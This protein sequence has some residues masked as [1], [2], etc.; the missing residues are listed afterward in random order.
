M[1]W[2][3]HGG[4]YIVTI[5]YLIKTLFKE[6]SFFQGNRRMILRKM[7]LSELSPKVQKECLGSQC[8]N[9]LVQGHGQP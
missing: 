3:E 1:P 4:C 7:K 5:K 8:N 2:R 6:Y 9:Q